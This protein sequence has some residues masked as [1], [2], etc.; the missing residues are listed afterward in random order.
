M[1]KLIG[2]LFLLVIMGFAGYFVYVNYIKEDKIIPEEELVSIN[3][4]YIY[5][6]HLNIKGELQI[7]DMTYQDIYLTFVDYLCNSYICTIKIF[8]C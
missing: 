1:K 8:N 4:Y 7:E 5:G 2:I 6:D 3:E